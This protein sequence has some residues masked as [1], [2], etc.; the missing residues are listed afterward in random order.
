MSCLTVGVELEVKID[1]K[2]IPIKSQN[3]EAGIGAL[4]WPVV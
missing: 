4:A 3:P 1:S 2:A